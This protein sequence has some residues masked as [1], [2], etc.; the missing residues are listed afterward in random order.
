[1]TKIDMDAFTFFDY[2]HSNT[3]LIINDYWGT[4][5]TS[6][7][8]YQNNALVNSQSAIGYTTYLY[9]V[10]SLYFIWLL[11]LTQLPFVSKEHIILYN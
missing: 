7:L 10:L 5:T 3:V 11:A 9:T 8:W 2:F 1:M 4:M 6:R